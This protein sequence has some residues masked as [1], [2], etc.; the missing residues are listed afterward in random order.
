MVFLWSFTRAGGS[1]SVKNA[2]GCPKVERDLNFAKLGANLV[3]Q[4]GSDKL[5]LS[6]SSR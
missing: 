2:S 5:L 4:A 3:P 6:L 1:G